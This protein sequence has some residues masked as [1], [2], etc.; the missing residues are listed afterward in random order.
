MAR[1]K[2]P[3]IVVAGGDGRLTEAALAL[4]EGG[5]EVCLWR[6][7]GE[8]SAP[9]DPTDRALSLLRPRPLPDKES[10]RE[11]G[12]CLCSALPEGAGGDLLLLPLPASRDGVR[13]HGAGAP[14]VAEAEA[15]L[16][17][18]GTVVGGGLSASLLASA[19][20]AGARVYD[21]LEDPAFV[22]A[23]A[24]LTAEATLG[25]LLLA[26]PFS[27]AETTLLVVGFGRIGAILVRLARSV[28]YQVRV[29]A[30]RELSR[31][32]AEELGARAFSP[33]RLGE[34]AEGV[35]WICNTVP[36]PLF[37]PA[38]WAGL[39]P[40]C[41]VVEL[42]GGQNLPDPALTPA[43]TVGLPALP[44]RVYPRSAG[45]LVALAAL[46]RLSHIEEHT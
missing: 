21:L 33:D 11:A 23:N 10:L 40:S 6:A 16:G 4:A 39:D 46:D 5:A 35:R 8:E 2:A 15:A 32:Q 30:R 45:R 12:V 25:Y 29:V 13:L 43:A 7:Y 37:S 14:T 36:Y 42:A 26:S 18:F 3:K 38:V 20:R 1:D 31:L 44:G 34:A 27:P 19:R 28:G 41:T 9:K 17:R 22:Y 24:R